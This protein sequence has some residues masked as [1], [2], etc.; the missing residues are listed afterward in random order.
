M[1]QALA[2]KRE[3]TASEAM[4]NSQLTNHEMP[5][6]MRST[7]SSANLRMRRCTRCTQTPSMETDDSSTK[8]R[9]T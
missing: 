3:D 6:M 1:P 7:T 5:R 9:L 2:V 4:S 8:R